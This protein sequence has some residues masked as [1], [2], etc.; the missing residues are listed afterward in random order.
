M[1]RISTAGAKLLARMDAPVREAH[2]RQ[3]GHLGPRRLTALTRLLQSA[4]SQ[5][6]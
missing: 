1:T 2:R 5:I 6:A 3:L 4:R